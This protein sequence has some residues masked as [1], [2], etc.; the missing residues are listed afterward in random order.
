MHPSMLLNYLAGDTRGTFRAKSTLNYDCWLFLTTFSASSNSRGYRNVLFLHDSGIP[1]RP[2]WK[3]IEM[4]VKRTEKGQNSRNIWGHCWT[5]QSSSTNVNENM[6]KWVRIGLFSFIWQQWTQLFV[7]SHC[8]LYF[9]KYNPTSK[10]SVRES[11]GQRFANLLN[12]YFIH[13][14]T[15]KAIKCWK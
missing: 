7:F 9:W 14:W 11:R 2:V 13:N 12:Q 1:W 8:T 4:S 5:D 10:K 15:W 6:E 3:Y